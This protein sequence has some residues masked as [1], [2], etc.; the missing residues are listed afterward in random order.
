MRQG[1]LLSLL[2]FNTVPVALASVLSQEKYTKGIKFGK[3]GNKKVFS[4]PGCLLPEC[5]HLVIVHLATHFDLC[6][7]Q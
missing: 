1:C 3:W 7:F 5:V 4:W 6:T 2:L